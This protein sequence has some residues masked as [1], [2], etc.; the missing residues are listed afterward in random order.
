MWILLARTIFVYLLVF[1]TM[2]I[3][4]KREIGKLSVFDLV[5][6]IM[7]AEIAVFVLEDINKPILEG[8]LPMFA[9]V[10]IQMVIALLSL[11]FEKLR[12]FFEGKPSYIIENG[13]LNREE[14]K[15]QRYNLDDLLL[16]LRQSQVTDVNDVEFA[17]LEPSGKLTVVEKKTHPSD[18]EPSDE[19][20]PSGSY[21]YEGLPLPLIMDG[22]VQ[23]EG[24]DKIGK[25][26]FWLKNELQLKGIKD[27]KDVFFC[28]Y[29]YRGKWYIDRRKK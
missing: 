26:R 6:W 13:S 3:M 12:R 21:R 11:K 1:V 24:L 14:M 23:D 25:T 15:S 27:F 7:I 16:Q 29:D 5:I 20:G 22:K 8:I 17:I 4:G 2:R 9:L 19:S 28:T 18:G 10:A